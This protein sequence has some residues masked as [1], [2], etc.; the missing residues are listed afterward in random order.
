MKT[1]IW[2][3]SHF[4]LIELLRAEDVAG[5]FRIIGSYHSRKY[6]EAL[7]A[8]VYHIEPAGL[9][10]SDYVE[11]ALEFVARHGVDVFV[12]GR[13]LAALAH[14]DERFR[15]LGCKLISA[16][17]G[18]T[19]ELLNNKVECY[20]TITDGLVPLPAY[21]VAD[22][23]E[24]FEQAVLALSATQPVVCFKPT[25]SIFGFGFRIIE[26]A[27]NAPLLVGVP[28]ELVTTFEG[29]L[30]YVQRGESFDQQMVMEYLPGQETSVDCLSVDGKLIRAVVRGKNADGSRVLLDRPL[31]VEYARRLTEKFKLTSLYNVQFREKGDGSPVLLEINSRMSG[32]TNMSCMSGLT[33]PYWGIK[34]ALGTASEAEIPHGRTGIRVA[35]LRRAVVLP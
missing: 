32:G 30:E 13:K 19:H 28:R 12:I 18:A 25:E 21:Q 3:H 31:F 35:E 33:L 23:P 1:T 10:E 8:D 29:A 27:E 24:A 14:A 7:L 9:S 17:D 2:L 34:L 26:T 16:C 5:E 22:D 15:A 11:W 4:N 6:P 20:N